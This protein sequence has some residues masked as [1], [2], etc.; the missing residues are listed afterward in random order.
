MTRD[1]ARARARR[2]FTHGI[3]HVSAVARSLAILF[4][5]AALPPIATTHAQPLPESQPIV[6]TRGNLARFR[7]ALAR[8]R[9]GEGLA[10]I[11][12]VGDSAVVGDELTG[13]LR[14]R[15]QSRYGD[16]GHGFLPAGKPWPWYT[17][18]HVRHQGSG[19][20]YTSVARPTSRT[21]RLFGLHFLRATAT[22]PA[23]AVWG[24]VAGGP[25]GRT[26]SRFELFYLAQPG[27]GALRVRLDDTAPRTLATA[28]ESHT[29]AYERI[30]VPD[31]AH[32]LALDT[33][34]D[35][36]VDVFGASMERASGVVVDAIG[37]NGAHSI[38]FLQGDPAL[39]TEHLR[40]RPPALLAIQ[41][42]TNMSNGLRPSR[43]GDRLIALMRRLQAA[44]PDA[45]C[46]LISPPDR[47]RRRPDGSEGTPDYI[48]AVVEQTE[49]A[50]QE[51]GCAYWSAFDAMGGAGSFVRWR[52]HEL[53]GRDEAHLTR[54]GY[55]RLGRLLDQ[56]LTG[57]RPR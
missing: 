49:R 37:I 12:Y 36:P 34:G 43:H 4:V 8:A 20:A 9:S 31:G 17:H 23:S 3:S 14:E 44:A 6:D 25:I 52:T 33:A 15:L 40:H 16:G 46:L 19:W 29:A 55:A 57:D 41:L 50:A 32:T 13:A 47:A 39:L 2:R 28:A 38:H 53:A 11:F 35:G 45:A 22:G 56:A 5:F 30:D 27:G 51:T 10:R 48:P 7:A 26:V 1:T 42:G 18:A 54:G 21:D 24:T